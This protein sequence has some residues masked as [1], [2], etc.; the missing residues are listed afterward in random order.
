M[1][2]YGQKWTKIAKHM[3]R[4]PDNVRDKFRTLREEKYDP[5]KEQTVWKF[6]QL[7]NFLKYLQ[8]YSKVKFLNESNS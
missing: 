7:V 8:K 4:T 6:E 2:V 1:G 3:H 5:S